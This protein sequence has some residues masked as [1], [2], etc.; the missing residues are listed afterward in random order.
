MNSSDTV[1]LELDLKHETEDAYLVSDGDED[2]WLP[3]SLVRSVDELEGDT[4]LITIP[5]WLAKDRGL[6]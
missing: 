5:E 6:V 3:K 4:V 2:V 1:E